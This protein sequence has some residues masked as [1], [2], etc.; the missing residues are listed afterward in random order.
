M[1]VSFYL[2]F[3]RSVCACPF[4]PDG[5]TL[6]SRE[7]PAVGREGT[8]EEHLFP[9]T[10]RPGQL[11][12]SVWRWRSEEK[13]KSRGQCW[14]IILCF[15]CHLGVREERRT[16]SSAWILN[17]L[18]YLIW[19]ETSSLAPPHTF[20]TFPS[21]LS[22]SANDQI[23]I[24]HVWKSLP[25]SNALLYCSSGSFNSFPVLCSFSGSLGALVIRNWEGELVY[26]SSTSVTPPRSSLP[27]LLLFLSSSGLLSSPCLKGS[28]MVEIRHMEGRHMGQFHHC[29]LTLTLWPAVI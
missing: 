8:K 1:F 2:E 19:R 20:Q 13:K 27:V 3:V 9:S 23:N 26:S 14:P 10:W 18:G 28:E 16:Q 25:A 4:D 6:S 5:Q 12:C 22:V 17:R 21:S 7:G 29:G 15:Q 11:G 24:W